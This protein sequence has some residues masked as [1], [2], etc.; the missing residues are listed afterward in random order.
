MGS[1]IG[2]VG[3]HILASAMLRPGAAIW[4]RDKRLNIVA[5]RLGVAWT[6]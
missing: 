5:H 4:T 3:A 1:G 6:S 2:Y